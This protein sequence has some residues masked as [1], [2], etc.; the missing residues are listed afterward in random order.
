MFHVL[1]LSTVFSFY[2]SIQAHLNFI[3]VR[4]T[5][6]PRHSP[7]LCSPFCQNTDIK[8][9]L[10]SGLKHQQPQILNMSTEIICVYTSEH[11][12]FSLL[13]N[14]KKKKSNE[15]EQIKDRLGACAIFFVLTEPCS[16]PSAGV[17]AGVGGG[18]GGRH[19]CF[20]PCALARRRGPIRK[21]WRNKP[22]PVCVSRCGTAAV[23]RG[24]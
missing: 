13:L 17:S 12:N 19:A 9:K 5:H 10:Q 8:A 21:E 11:G 23:Q 1:V 7:D 4:G 22:C 14:S 2:F 18:G 6:P 20:Y 24:G 16:S 15:T 3:T